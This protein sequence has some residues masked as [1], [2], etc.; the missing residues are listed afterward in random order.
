MRKGLLAAALGAV[1]AF[2]PTAAAIDSAAR[3]VSGELM[4]ASAPGAPYRVFAEQADGTYLL[5]AYGNLDASGSRRLLL[6]ARGAMGNG[7]PQ[8]RISLYVDGKGVV[9]A[10]PDEE[11]GWGWD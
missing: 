4:I 1:A 2:A 3:Y 7:Q 8:F 9:L 5:A 6:P 11:A 10:I